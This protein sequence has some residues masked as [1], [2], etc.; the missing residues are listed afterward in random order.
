MHL[1]KSL[2]VLYASICLSSVSASAEKQ[3]CI[4]VDDKGVIQ[5]K[6]S[7]A[8]VPAQ[9]KKVAKCFAESS[10]VH[11]NLAAPEEIS[12][13]GTIRRET[14]SSPLGR[15]Q[16]RWPRKV[17]SLF[18][19]TPERAVAEAASAVRKALLR[20]GFPESL[21]NI[22]V[23]W[24]IVFLDETLPEK[25]IPTYLVT[26][27]HPA[28][29]TPPANLYIV[30]QRVIAGC[31]NNGNSVKRSVADSELA[32]ILIHEMGHALEYV[33]LGGVEGRDRMRAEGFASWF[34]QYASDFSSV[35]QKGKM[36]SFYSSLARTSFAQS[37]EVFTFVGSAHD[38][39]R[40]SMYFHAIVSRKGVGGLMDVYENIKTTKT[41]F[42]QSVQKVTGW[43]QKK[44]DAEARR[45]AGAE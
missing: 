21:R 12:L 33:L 31:T 15:I 35:V 4:F 29:M 23:P 17:E 27:C 2:V 41:S 37:P 8:G 11:N 40:A 3:I 30:S 22:D 45:A 7:I 18:G 28:W 34:E 6:T 42:M 1:T 20:G 19:R 24:D 13:E 32:P 38:Y 43:N 25:Q 5:Q 14:I 26:N 39:A 44:L 36:E 16:I 10:G 9:F